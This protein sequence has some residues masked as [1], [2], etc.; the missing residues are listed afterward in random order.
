MGWMLFLV[1]LEFLT[2]FFAK[3]KPFWNPFMQALPHYMLWASIPFLF[4]RIAA[5][6]WIVIAISFISLVVFVSAFMAAKFNLAFSGDAFFVIFASSP[7]EMQEFISCFFGGAPLVI[8]LILLIA[9]IGVIT[10]LYRRTWDLHLISFLLGI[11]LLIPI[12]GKTIRYIHKKQ[13]YK[14]YNMTAVN[15]L[16]T[17]AKYFYEQ[18]I[19]LLDMVKN[20]AIPEGIKLTSEK[21]E[22]I[23]GI[24]IIGESSS[25]RHF[26]L[27]GYSRRTN[28]FMSF[29]KDELFIAK[30]A[31]TAAPSTT[32]ALKYILTDA[33]LLKQNPSTFTLVD[34][35]KKAG[36][37]VYLLS[38]QPRW[39]TADSPI[40]MFFTHADDLIYLSEKDPSAYD[41]SLLEI[42]DELCKK[43]KNDKSPSVII[44]NLMG[45]HINH[46]LRYPK[47]YAFFNGL[48]DKENEKIDEKY[49]ENVNIYDNTIRFSDMVIKKFTDRV[50]AAKNPAF[51]VYLADHGDA[52]QDGISEM[53]AF[54]TLNPDIYEVPFIIYFN[55]QYRNDFPQT[56][57]DV[58]GAVS[59]PLQTDR[60]M[61]G[62]LRLYQITYKDFP[63][64]ED[65]FSAQFK[66]KKRIIGI[67]K[68]Y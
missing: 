68:E 67:N 65:F 63:N 56:V 40:S 2:M 32:Q 62:L 39:G 9:A 50:A 61:H 22:N 17:G 3:A 53:R 55:K 44:I 16:F 51:M 43:I 42:Y 47:E 19:D 12:F 27:Y 33:E 4:G 1:L 58:F 15:R 41:D 20:P 35:C 64:E 25:R 29:Y 36:Y 14:L 49:K 54:G 13:T 30:N 21:A 11:C 24:F 52:P 48:R 6:I 37:K 10:F 59:R 7:E 46:Y 5:R 34:V 38:N 60:I 66:E 26:E 8:F 57:K 28:P 45:S 18:Y 23:H 31:I